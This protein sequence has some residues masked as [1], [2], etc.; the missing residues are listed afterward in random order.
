MHFPIDSQWVKTGKIIV[1][2][3]EPKAQDIQLFAI[4]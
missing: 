1:L 2:M 4:I 3:L